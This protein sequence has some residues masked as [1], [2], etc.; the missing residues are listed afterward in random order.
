MI[1][2]QSSTIKVYIL[3]QYTSRYMMNIKENIN[4]ALFMRYFVPDA[5]INVKTGGISNETT[6][7]EFNLCVD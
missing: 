3:I 1:K 7:V 6:K 4:M 2:R 5:N